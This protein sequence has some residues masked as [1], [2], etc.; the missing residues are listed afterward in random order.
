MKNFIE[1]RVEQKIFLNALE[2]K[3]NSPILI[4][5]KQQS[6][7]FIDKA[8]E[9]KRSRSRDKIPKKAGF[10]KKPVKLEIKKS[11]EKL[12]K[13]SAPLKNFFSKVI[14]FYKN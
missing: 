2:S 7:V 5:S 3:S 14:G 13:K 8:S 10:P 9:I 11:V 4:S 6:V 12:S 1:M